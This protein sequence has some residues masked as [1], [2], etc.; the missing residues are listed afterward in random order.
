MASLGN[1]LKRFPSIETG[2]GFQISR[3]VKYAVDHPHEDWQFT[4]DVTKLI[5]MLPPLTIEGKHYDSAVF[6]R[7]KAGEPASTS[8]EMACTTVVEMPQAAIPKYARGRRAAAPTKVT[9]TSSS[10][11]QA[12]AAHGTAATRSRRNVLTEAQEQEL[13]C[14]TSVLHLPTNV[15][16]VPA[17]AYVHPSMASRNGFTGSILPP[18]ASAPVTPRSQPAPPPPQSS[19][20]PD[21][22]FD[23]LLDFESPQSQS[24]LYLDD[25]IVASPYDH[26][27]YVDMGAGPLFEFDF[28]LLATAP[29]PDNLHTLPTAERLYEGDVYGDNPFDP[30]PYM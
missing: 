20:S 11:S 16:P 25:G 24:A 3:C 10:S 30:F 5:K 17:P 9:K 7:F 26:G 28:D 1:D 2:D 23:Q 29:T 13:E 27:M 21:F 19:E 12:R 22:D 14:W 15:Q 6:A 18:R 4:R 8:P